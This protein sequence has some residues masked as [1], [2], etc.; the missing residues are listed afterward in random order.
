MILNRMNKNWVMFGL[1]YGLFSTFARKL[2]K[3]EG[4]ASRSGKKKQVVVL[5]QFYRPEPFKYPRDIAM[6]LADNNYEV[7]VVT[8]YPNRP[9][10]KLYPGY[11]QRFRFSEVIDGISVHRV[12]IVINH[13]HKALERIA[14]FLS[15]SFNALRLTSTVKNADA[16]Y[17]YATPATAAIPA[18]VWAKILGIPY[19]L[20]V[21]DLW[22]ESVTGSE[23]MGQGAISRVAEAAMTPWLKRLYGKADALVAIS[24]GMRDLLVEKGN[25]AESTSVVYNWAE[26]ESITAKT[27]NL[28]ESNDLRLLYAGNL[29]PMQD[30][31]TVIEVASR[32]DDRSDFSLDIA[33]GGILEEAIQAAAEE[34]SQTNFLGLIPRAEIS[35]QYFKSD[36]QLVTL[37]DMAIFRTTIPS[38][39]QASLASGVPVITTVK[40][41]VAELIKRYDAGLVAEPENAD[42][43]AAAFDEALGMSTAE[44]ARMGKNARRLYEEQMS[45]S[46]GTAAIVSIMDKVIGR[47]PSNGT[48][49]R[50]LSDVEV[51]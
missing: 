42:S 7:R 51:G 49:G 5:S 11:R 33:G 27:S 12:P 41:D 31:E 6:A 36:F 45:R 3:H 17:V 48:P 19:V 24:P 37:K 21:Q 44:R 35:R 40:G 15:F 4:A 28:F 8:G 16:V 10:G 20:H 13:S 38:K 34:L 1:K 18:Q 39:L 25:S 2:T 43:L 14:N 30:L 23:M 32:Y 50:S 9:G 22:P 46:A 29:G 47:E 26:E